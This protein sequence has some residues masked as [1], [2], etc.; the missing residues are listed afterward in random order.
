MNPAESHDEKLRTKFIA[1]PLSISAAENSRFLRRFSSAKT[2][3][4]FSSH[5]YNFETFAADSHL[6]HTDLLPLP[7][8]K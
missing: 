6:F 5:C 1:L 3:G 7:P 2:A 4:S 8:T